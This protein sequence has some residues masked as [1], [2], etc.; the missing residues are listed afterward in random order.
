MANSPVLSH[1]YSLVNFPRERA[2][3]QI[4]KFGKPEYVRWQSNTLSY[5]SPL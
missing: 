4:Q 3:I 1:G 5:H 2:A